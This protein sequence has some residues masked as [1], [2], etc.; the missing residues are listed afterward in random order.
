MS[1]SLSAAD[2]LDQLEQRFPAALEDEIAEL[3]ER[4]ARAERVLK[5]IRNDD[6]PRRRRGGRDDAEG[7]ETTPR[8]TIDKT[9]DPRD[10]V[11][12][13]LSANGPSGFM[14]ILKAVGVMAGPLKKVL[15]G[16]RSFVFNESQKT[17]G[18]WT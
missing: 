6:G 3:K 8:P 17:W 11:A 16:D 4:L 10:R 15:E 2:L 1:A 13:F 18:L 12:A 9:V 14:S 5:M 7:A